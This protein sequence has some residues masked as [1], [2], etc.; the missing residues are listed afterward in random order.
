MTLDNA[1]SDFEKMVKHQENT[2]TYNIR[3]GG[4]EYAKMAKA[5]KKKASE[6]RQLAEW[7]KDY[8]R[9]KAQEPVLNKIRAEI[10]QM[11]TISLN[12]NDIY[13]AD[14]IA[15]IDKYRVESEDKE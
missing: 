14:V 11:P 1:I 7:L 10:K 3:H 5:N 2:A 6:Y 9:L 4:T 8:K 13:K 12:A 15:I